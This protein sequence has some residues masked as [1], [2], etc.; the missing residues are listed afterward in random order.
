[1]SNRLTTWE[2]KAVD[3]LPDLIGRMQKIVDLMQQQAALSAQSSSAIQ[4]QLSNLSNSYNNLQKQMQGVT[5]VQQ[6][7]VTATN[8]QAAATRQMQ[9]Q[10]EALRS[11]AV[12]LTTIMAGVFSASKAKEFM[13]EV[14]DA[15]TR[16]NLF[17]KSLEA[18]LKN[19]QL[20]DEVSAYALDMAQR[21]PL[22]VKQIMEVTQ[23]LVA[24]GAEGGKVTQYLEMLGEMSSAVGTQKLPLIA[25]ALLDVQNKQK[26]YAQEIRQ[27]TDNGV[28]LFQL[29]ADSMN[30]PIAKV[31]QLADEHKISFAQVEKALLDATKQGGI[32][33]GSM[34]RNAEELG[35]KLSNLSDVVFLAKAKFG[36]FIKEGLGNAITATSNFI[37]SITATDAAMERTINAVK[38]VTAA[39]V[40][41]SLATQAAGVIMAAKAVIVRTYTIALGTSQIAL[42]ALSGAMGANITITTGATVAARAFWATLATN[43]I[44]LV[45]SAVGI[46]TT[47]YYTWKATTSEMSRAQEELTE[48]ITKSTAPLELARI[49]FSKLGATILSSKS[50]AEQKAAAFE[51]LQKLYPLQMAGITSL[52]E[53][54]RKLSGLMKE[55]NNDFLIRIKLLENEVRT[56]VNNEAAVAAVRE[57]I[58]LE[59]EL[60]TAST[61]RAEIYGTAGKMEVYSDAEVLK[62]RIA[63]LDT[64]IKKS[65]EFNQN[66]AFQSER[67]TKEINDD[68]TAKTA[69]RISSAAAADDKAN[70]AKKAKA[71]LTEKEI[72]I[73]KGEIQ[74]DSLNDELKLIDLRRDLEIQRVNRTTLTHQQAEAAVKEIVAKAE[75]DKAALR[76]K[77]SADREKL[78]RE[79]LAVAEAT[80]TEETLSSRDLLE[81]KKFDDKEAAKSKKEA[82]K[83]IRLD[84]KKTKEEEAE[85]Q[86]EI[87][88]IHKMEAEI[89][90]NR[91]D[92]E[93]DSQ[94]DRIKMAFDYLG[95]QEGIIGQLSKVFKRGFEDWDLLNGKT[96]EGYKQSAQAARDHLTEISKTHKA[97][98]D[99]YKQAE[100]DV[101]EKEKKL[102][103]AK[104]AALKAK[105]AA[106]MAV[107]E[108]L[109]ITKNAIVGTITETMQAVAKVTLKIRDTMKDL[110]D[111]LLDMNQEA[112]DSQLDSNKE[113]LDNDL[114][115]HQ[116]T[117]AEKKKIVE[118]YYAKQTTLINNFYATQKRLAESRDAIDAQLTFNARML[119][120]N[121]ETTTKIS[122]AWD[123]SKGPLGPQTLFKVLTAWK[124]HNAQLKAAAYEREAYEKQ[125]AIERVQ[126]EKEKAREIRDAKIAA[127]ED[128]MDAFE[129]AIDKKIELAE[130]AAD[131][132]IK[133]EEK[134]LEA[135]K[136]IYDKAVDAAKKAY[137]KQVEDLKTKQEK[138]DRVYE[139][140]LAS[141]KKLY[142]DQLDALKDKQSQE[143]AALRATYDLKQSLLE[144]E[145]SDEIG[146]IG[147]IDRVRNEALER[148]RIDEVARLTA[149]RDRILATLTDEG[150]RA[151]ITADFARQIADVHAEV[152]TAKLEKSKGV[153][154]ATKQLNAEQKEETVKLKEEEKTALQ[155]LDDKYQKLFKDLAD[156][157]DIKLQAMADANETREQA[158]KDALKKI[159]DAHDV[160]LTSLRD[161]QDA[162]EQASKDAIEKIQTELKNTIKGLKQEIADKDAQINGQMKAANDDYKNAVNQ[163]N[164]DIFNL[165]KQM[166][167][168]ELMAEIA[169]LRGKRN[170]FN[171]GKIDSAIDD[172]NAAIGDI[173]GLNFDAPNVG[174][175]PPPATPP[176]GGDPGGNNPPD[177]NNPNPN[178]EGPKP[179]LFF[180]G[181]PYIE[182]LGYPSG[183]DT[184]PAMVNKGER[185][186]QTHLNELIGGR[187]VSNE[188]LAAKKL[189]ADRVLGKVADIRGLLKRDTF[190]APL[191]SYMMQGVGSGA[192]NLDEIANRIEAA[193]QR[194]SVH[195]TVNPRGLSVQEKGQRKQNETYYRN[196]GYNRSH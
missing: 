61:K 76:T 79:N 60:S 153:S 185:V 29:L 32:Y 17:S 22:E 167:I 179:E 103:E 181:T 173:R 192:A 71:I 94:K 140:E 25:K 124:E 105:T 82:N 35:G 174:G 107:L 138:E 4:G 155:A 151:A 109:E 2:L 166:K 18:M 126:F 175:T 66:I 129:K 24:M 135:S 10:Y 73:L 11:T 43:P 50:S 177:P 101:V 19:K 33:Y 149:T 95:A 16:V 134:K 77:Y 42:Q 190:L 38:A 146:K 48:R 40:T 28:P 165:T 145:T 87:S 3:N 133:A 164:R 108:L 44:G 9:Q 180:E 111:D 68:W 117:F 143:E 186:M 93:R 13:L 69:D 115:A 14:V 53:A 132:E 88:A 65:Q 30:L 51:K 123:L 120:I 169:I 183:R 89:I 150:E 106:A 191:P 147:I 26:L 62:S 63:K 12:S 34:A 56:Q 113:G 136:K 114:K 91:N 159:E 86:K 97:G 81:A 47:A 49:E 160:Y 178:P 152:E 137:D 162:R 8:Q 172:L 158:Q 58:K 98:S 27:F 170:L 84:N 195:V 1:M 20:A 104:A 80:F 100:S 142:D 161:A 102:E 99:L 194:P 189:F 176:G 23:R 96:I 193:M 21:S 83:E 154:L 121:S 188:E 74:R 131:G 36:E 67:L 163:A 55:V 184:V 5:T 118:D 59:G 157:R 92:I 57:K 125:L 122:S 127:L 64:T 75:A 110:Y 41:Y 52:A 54:E 7:Q 112:L 130:A 116:G 148:Y 39:V 144:Q 6:Q 168:A 72:A 156:E 31:R 139:K 15:N 85:L 119:E 78:L 196:T 46:A 45:I 70:K 182:G 37:K 90:K 187:A 141:V 128:E 171:R